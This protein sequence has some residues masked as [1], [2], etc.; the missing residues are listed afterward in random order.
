MASVS[1]A[2]LS[3]D[4][5]NALNDFQVTLTTV[6]P[7]TSTGTTFTATKTTL[8][9]GFVV[10][11]NGREVEIDS[12]F[13]INIDGVSTYPSKGW[14]V[15]DGTRDL[16]VALVTTGADGQLYKLECIARRQRGR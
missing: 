14:V 5:D 15:N 13:Y 7:T 3:A 11:E 6:L 10:E 16:K 8:T 1:Q 12:A 9:Q 2:Q 4:I